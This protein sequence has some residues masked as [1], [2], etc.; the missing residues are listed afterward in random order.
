MVSNDQTIP[1][2]VYLHCDTCLEY[3]QVEDIDFSV[4]DD[5]VLA[6][7]NIVRGTCKKCGGKASASIDTESDRQQIAERSVAYWRKYHRRGKKTTT[8]ENI[9]PVR[10]KKARKEEKPQPKTAAKRGRPAG[11]GTKKAAG[12]ASGGTATRTRHY[13]REEGQPTQGVAFCIVGSGGLYTVSEFQTRWASLEK[14]GKIGQMV[15][16]EI[17]TP[18]LS[19]MCGQGEIEVDGKTVEFYRSRDE[20][21][22]DVFGVPNLADALKKGARPGKITRKG[23]RL[24]FQGMP[25]VK[26][27]KELA[28]A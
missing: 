8:K 13:V 3:V 10:R 19:Y 12:K 7:R 16:K 24:S 5:G 20:D 6:G 17:G 2:Y 14:Q 18:D 4:A 25:L 21:G 1:Q 15:D 23:D 22:N 27:R 9:V 26:A 28:S 11:S